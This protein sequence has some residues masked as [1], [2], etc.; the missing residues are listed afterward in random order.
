MATMKKLTELTEDELCLILEA[1]CMMPLTYEVKRQVAEE[2][3]RRA[4]VLADRLRV[5]I[6]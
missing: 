3:D 4:R 5:T 6:Y 2:L 1:D